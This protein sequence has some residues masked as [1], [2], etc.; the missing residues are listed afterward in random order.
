MISMLGKKHNLLFSLTTL[1]LQE[2]VGSSF[3]LSAP[4]QCHFSHVGPNAFARTS[5]T[6]MGM[7]STDVY[8]G[9]TNDFVDGYVVNDYSDTSSEWASS[10]DSETDETDD[11]ET[12]PSVEYEQVNNGEISEKELW[13]DDDIWVR[14]AVDEINNAYTAVDGQP[15]YDTS[16]DEPSA[17]HSIKDSIERKMDDEIAML[18][19]CNERPESLLIEEGRALPP[20]SEEEKNDVSQLVV[21]NK[22]TFEATEF[23]RDAVSKMFREHA[24]PSVKDGILSMDRAGVASW[25]TKSLQGVEKGKVSQHD[26]RVLRTLSSFGKY[27]SGRMVEEEFQNLYLDCIVG[28]KPSSAKRHLEF[29]TDFRDAVWRDICAHGMLP[30]IEKERLLFLEKINIKDSELSSRGYIGGSDKEDEQFF[31]DECEILDWDFRA[32]EQKKGREHGEDYRLESSHRLVDM[33]NDQK[34]P[35]RIQDGDFVFIDEESCIGCL[36]CS[37]IA[38]SSFLMLESGRARTFVQR[39]GVDV[40]EAV[41]AC[42]VNCMHKV[43]FQELSTMETAREKMEDSP[44][45]MRHIPLHVAGMDSD[46]NRR[47]SLYHTLQAKCV[48]STSCPQKGCYDCPSY[49]HPGENPF[50]IAKHKQA[51]HVRAQHFIKNGDAKFFRKY[52]EL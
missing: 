17:D 42:P 4:S 50:F 9:G 22:D 18:V 5:M 1:F 41:D 44:H 40:K 15:L 10:V 31:V 23:L 30:P 45:R 34:T 24:A 29:R 35:L 8:D 14:D 46:Q 47:S 36:K 21:W 3:H 13:S 38:P 39:A 33:S 51:E 25:M 6:C 7:S 52:V 43:S 20:L 12:G 27:G 11:D 49:R 26:K 37:N 2:D 28:D 32:P 19:R 48:T 16:F